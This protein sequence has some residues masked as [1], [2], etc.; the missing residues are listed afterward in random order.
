MSPLLR[1]TRES[2]ARHRV[3]VRCWGHEVMR[4][5]SEAAHGV[6]SAGREVSSVGGR[7]RGHRRLDIGGDAIPKARGPIR[8]AIRSKD[9]GTVL[10][11]GNGA[12]CPVS[13]P[14]AQELTA[15][16]RER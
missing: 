13:C 15:Q 9:R 16:V 7:A 8:R 1:C 10:F 5:G 2:T 12:V 3:G 4:P 14:T 6:D 11:A